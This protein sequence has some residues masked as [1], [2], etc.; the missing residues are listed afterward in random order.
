M[1]NF[2]DYS[3]STNLRYSTYVNFSKKNMDQD[4]IEHTTLWGS[5]TIQKIREPIYEYSFTLIWINAQD[6][7]TF[8]DHLRLNEYAIYAE[9][10]KTLFWLETKKAW[11][12]KNIDIS[13]DNYIWMWLTDTNRL[14]DVRF[15]FSTFTF[16]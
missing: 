8:L 12:I 3:A 5:K 9:Y 6:F 11:F 14:I 16:N 2:Y 15:T 13:D 7:Y 10:S 4:L 1:L